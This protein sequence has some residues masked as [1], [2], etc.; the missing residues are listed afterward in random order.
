MMRYLNTA[1]LATIAALLGFQIYQTG[2][3]DCRALP[4]T[5]IPTTLTEEQRTAAQHWQIPTCRQ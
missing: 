2:L 3:P 4:R 1:L 5:P